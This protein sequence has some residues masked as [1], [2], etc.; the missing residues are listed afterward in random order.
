VPENYQG[1]GKSDRQAMD[2][3]IKAPWLLRILFWYLKRLANNNPEGF[4]AQLEADLSQADKDQIAQPEVRKTL[5]NATVEAFQQGGRGAVW[6]Y[7]MVGKPWG[8]KLEDIQMPV[9]LWHGEEDKICSIKMGRNIAAA[10]P[11][12]E[13]HFIPGEGHLS[14]YAKYYGEILS[15]IRNLWDEK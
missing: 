9:H 11:D 15:T 2:L 3:A 14:V 12:C 6:D 4:L 13:V 1:L 8:F 7:A 10:I 5:V